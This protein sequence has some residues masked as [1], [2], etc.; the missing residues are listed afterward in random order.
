MPQQQNLFDLSSTE[1]GFDIRLQTFQNLMRHQIRDVLLVSSLYDLYLFE[2]DGRL[3][4]QIRN[5]YQGLSLSHPP[6]IIR[7][8]SGQE[9]LELVAEERRFDLIITTLHVEDMSSLSLA[10]RVKQL[11]LTIPVVLLNY[12]NQEYL[13]L[14][15]HHDVNVFDGIFIWQ[16]DFR[17]IIAMIQHLED[18]MNVENDTRV[19]GVQ[20]IILVEDNVLYYSKFLPIIYSQ[21]LKQSQ[22]LISEGVNLSHKY[23]RMRARPKILLA[24]TYEQAWEYYERYKEYI[25]GIISDIDFLH[26]GV[27]DPKAGLEFTRSVKAEYHDIPVLLQSTF[28]DNEKKANDLGAS[29]L[30]KDSPTLLH[31]LQDFIMENFGFGDF[32]FRTSDGKEVGRATDLKSMEG[33]LKTVPADS[34]Q[35][36]AERNHFSKWLKARTEFWLA[37]KLRP[38][39]VSD[40]PSVDGLRNDIISLLRQNRRFQQI[41]QITDFNKEAFDPTVSF[42]RIGGGSL[43]GKT[44]GLGFLNL[45]INHKGLRNRFEGVNIDVPPGIVIGTDVFDQFLDGNDLREF[46][47]SSKDDHEITRSFVEAPFFP[48]D[49]THALTE[50]LMLM[51]CPLAVRSSSLLEDSQYHP[52]AGVYETYMIP[53]NNTD[54]TIR[55]REL[56]ETIKRVYA[57]TF[58]QSAK[59]YIKITTY[60]LEEEKMAVIIMR[61][62]GTQHANRF[63]PDIS[64]VAKSHNYY[65]MPPQRSADGIVSVAL[66]LGKTIVEGGNTVRFSPRF[67]RLA[68]PYSSVDEVM[69]NSQDSF[70]SLDMDHEPIAASETHDVLLVRHEINDAEKDGTLRFAGSTYSPENEAIYDGLGRDGVRIIT[71]A[72]LLKGKIF[73]L[74]EIVDSLLNLG[75]SGMGSPVEMEFAVNMSVPE[76]SPKEFGVLQ[77]RPMVLGRESEVLNVEDV[78][79]DSVVCRSERVLGN[80]ILQD[81]YDIITVDFDRFERVRSREVAHEVGM[82]N[83]KMLQEKCP[84]ILVGVGRWG[85]LDPWLGIPVKYDQICGARV[86]VEAGL[87][88]IPVAPSQGSHF[89]QNITSFMVGYFTVQPNEIID[90]D[91]MRAQ[92]PVEETAYVRHLRFEYP[93]IVKMNGHSGKGVILKPNAP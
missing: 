80:G 81:L 39:K 77:V 8:S 90:W 64:G 33:Q 53:N 26:G 51:P 63:Y 62:V 20:S 92:I 84:Y 22:R 47:L 25:S 55:L 88:D 10:K 14:S 82:L 1:H 61:M 9:A 72:P 91:W 28:A 54:F 30:V 87:R 67:P 24:K 70:F 6:E 79:P 38:R 29:F 71:F 57:S 37:H 86:I 18:K 49:V 2:E 17:I 69:Q 68:S 41:G 36:H 65:P 46:A 58:Y 4:D 21:V 34:V 76:G 78:S 85:T 32:V 12:D 15:T 48:P 89:F 27:H 52:F 19:A 5:E 73:P 43:G 31:E 74:A 44:R 93:L 83:E 66:G 11:G 60:R 50:F 13:E 7:V 35:Y 56:I 45:L 40:Y 3:Y 59:D 23:L 42:A 75:K 16:G